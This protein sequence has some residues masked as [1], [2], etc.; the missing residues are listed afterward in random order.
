M[1]E[2]IALMFL[3]NRVKKLYIYIY[4]FFFFFFLIN[5]FFFLLRG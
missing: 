1:G 2:N 3:V 5:F 4:F